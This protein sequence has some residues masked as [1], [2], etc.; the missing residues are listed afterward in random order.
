MSTDAD[1]LS[2]QEEVDTD[3]YGDALLSAS[4]VKKYF[5][6]ETG[7]FERVIG[8]P[9]YVRAV[10]GVSLAVGEE[11]TLG[12]V[13]ESGC[14]KTTLG[15]VVSR[16][17]K[18]TDGIIKFDGQDIAGL[19]GKRLKQ[20][21]KDVQVIFQDPQ[22]SLNPR[23]TARE[24]VGR[25]ME[26]HD[27][28]SGEEKENRVIEL[29]EE[30]GLQRSHL[31]RYPHEFSGGQ[32]QRVGIARALAVEPRMIIA[33]EP[34]SALDVSVQAQIINL[35]KRLQSE[36]NLSYLF[37][38]HDLS[39]V[40]HISDRVAVM[41]LGKIVEQGRTDDI[42]TNPQHPYTR[43]LLHSI[44]SV[45]GVEKRRET[46]LEGN[47]PSPINPPSG[48]RFHTRCPE[49]IGDV[50]QQENPPLEPVPE[51]S[52]T[53]DPPDRADTAVASGDPDVD[54]VHQ[55]ACH[56]LSRSAEERQEQDPFT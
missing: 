40:K 37:I 56:W 31:D 50:C 5:E 15:R 20:L 6:T 49:Y 2:T 42:F 30:V 16:L 47:P 24:I 34:V 48:C 29:F 18:P 46:V 27:I 8:E 4:G 52:G 7:F 23:K 14:G 54:D 22:S 12:L 43:S 44:P 32:R 9:T 51:A 45:E 36:Y 35:M 55:A 38:A 21:R 41:Y 11:E 19:S 26:I 28:A 3:Q 25:P 1:Q 39:V 17:Y 53:I 33:D 13:G 10:D